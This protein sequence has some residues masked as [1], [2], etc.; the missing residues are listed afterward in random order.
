MARRDTFAAWLAASTTKSW[1]WRFWVAGTPP[2]SWM[3]EQIVER[4]GAD[5]D[6]DMESSSL[7]TPTVSGGADPGLDSSASGDIP[8]HWLRRARRRTESRY[9]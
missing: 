6:P 1:P 8:E 4:F 9:N 5:L 7:H 2:R 3:A